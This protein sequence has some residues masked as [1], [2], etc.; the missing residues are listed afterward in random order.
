MALG[1]A[2]FD[3]ERA[4]SV[5]NSRDGARVHLV[6]DHHYRGPPPTSLVMSPAGAAVVTEIR[7]AP[8]LAPDDSGGYMSHLKI[9][10]GCVGR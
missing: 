1:G 3:F 9:L 7:V 10:D 8:D 2:V 4:I 5:E 6:H